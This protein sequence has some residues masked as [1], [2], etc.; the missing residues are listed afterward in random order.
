[1]STTEFDFA[2]QQGLIF[3]EAQIQGF[4]DAY[5]AESLLSTDLA[6]TFAAYMEEKIQIILPYAKLWNKE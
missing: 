2:N 3:T 1:M 4:E 6:R 5:N